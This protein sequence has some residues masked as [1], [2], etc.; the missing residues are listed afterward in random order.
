MELW[1]QSTEKGQPRRSM[2]IARLRNGLAVLL[3]LA[4]TGTVINRVYSVPPAPP[5][6]PY[7]GLTL[8]RALF[9]GVGPLAAKIPTI[10]KSAPYFPAEYKS[11]E[12]EMTKYIQRKD[13]KFFERFA[14]DIQSGDRVKVAAAIKSA[15]KLQRESL[16]AVAKNSN[17]Q[18]ASQVRRVSDQPQPQPTPELI[19]DVVIIILDIGIILANVTTKTLP[20]ALK[21][22]SFE[23]YV[24]EIVHAVPK[25][26]P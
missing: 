10:R 15:N 16:F 21:G 23:R 14:G 24:D 2:I 12:G 17:T 7:D 19:T 3:A 11:L 22:L 6:V 26:T 13:P 5:A 18:F 9:F 20:D 4:L 1:R 25:A 8:Y